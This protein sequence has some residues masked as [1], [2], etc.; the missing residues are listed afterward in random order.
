MG[1]TGV[2]CFVDTLAILK[3]RDM[4]RQSEEDWGRPARP[5]DFKLASL[6][7]HLYGTGMSGAH[8]AL[9]DVHGLE[10]VLRAPGISERW[11]RIA[12]ANP[13]YQ[14]PVPSSLE[15]L[16]ALMNPPQPSRK[17]RG[18]RFNYFRKKSAPKN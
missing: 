13:T 11:R 18:G 6:Y 5:N 9:G 2:L 8:T 1:E 12:T 16:Q 4:W 15:E 10:S 3:D 7:E 14:I 17:G